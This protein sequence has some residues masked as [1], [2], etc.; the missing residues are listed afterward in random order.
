MREI[1]M[2]AVRQAVQERDLAID[3]A[4]MN[5]AIIIISIMLFQRQT[6]ALT[7]ATG[8]ENGL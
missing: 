8:G 6:R 5:K 4:R 7:L 1:I 2:E 3:L